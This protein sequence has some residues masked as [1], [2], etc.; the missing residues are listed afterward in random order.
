MRGDVVEIWPAYEDT[1]VRLSFFGDELEEIVSV[2]TLTGEIVGRHERIN[3]YPAKHFVV[4]EATLEQAIGGIK[5]ELAVRLGELNAAGKLLEAQRLQS[6]TTYDLDMLG[7]VGT[8]QGIENYSRHLTGR[9]PGERPYCLFDFLPPDFLCV[10]DE[11]HV[12][13]P[14]IGGMYAGDRSRK[15][16]LVAH[17]FRP[18]QRAR[19]PPAEVPRVGAADPAAALRLGDAGGLRGQDRGGAGRAAGPPDRHPRSAGVGAPDRRPGR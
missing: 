6:R 17:G 2:H 3:I 13:V 7:E 10:V 9:K 15:E 18:A 4:Q 19:Q 12:T 1:A 8:C 5:D 14:Q 11:S 16:T